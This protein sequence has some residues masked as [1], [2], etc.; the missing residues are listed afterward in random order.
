MNRRQPTPE[1]RDATTDSSDSTS[2]FCGV[3]DRYRDRNQEAFRT[4][5]AWLATT[6]R[7]IGD[8]VI[9]T[10]HDGR[11]IAMNEVAETLTGWSEAEA[12]GR[13]V[14]EVFSILR[15]K[16]RKEEENPVWQALAERRAVASA[17]DI[18]LIARDGAERRIADR[19]APVQDA[20]E[21]VVGAVLVFR[22][23]TNELEVTQSL[24]E[25]EKELVCQQRVSEAFRN[26]PPIDELCRRIVLCLI[27]GMQSPEF[28]LPEIDLG[29]RRFSRDGTVKS[30]T[31]A[32][33]ADIHLAGD[34]VGYV[35]VSYTV[36][37]PFLLPYEQDLVDTIARLLGQDLDRRHAEKARA[38]ALTRMAKTLG[39]TEAILSAL[40]VPV[41]TKDSDGRYLSCNRAFSE[42]TGRTADEIRGKTAD[43]LW[44]DQHA[45]RYHRK[46]LEMLRCGGRQEYELKIRDRHGEDREVLFVKDV[47]R[48]SEREIRGIVG[49]YIDITDRKRAELQL[50]EQQRLLKTILDGI[51]DIVAL[52]EPDHTVL[53]YNK[54][55]YDL[56]GKPPHEVHGKRCFELLGRSVPC[57]KCAMAVAI[58][59]KRPARIEKYVPELGRWILAN[60]IPIL[61][62]AGEVAM[63]VEQLQDITDHKHYEK[64]LEH[65]AHAL[66]SSNRALKEFNQLAESATRAKSEFLANMSHEIRTPMTAI[67]GFADYL[68]EE[69]GVGV[70]SSHRVDAIQTIQRNGNYLL[71]LINDILDLSKIEAGKLDIERSD[72]S[73]TKVLA[74][75]LALMRI[76]A[77]AK[78]IGLELAYV[79]EIPEVIQSDPLRFRQILINLIGN[80]IKFTESGQVH[81]VAGL[82]RTA[83]KPTLLSI[84]ITDT[85]VGLSAEQISRLFQPFSQADTSTTRKFGGSGLGLTISKRLAEKLG[86][87]IAVQSTPG[88]GSTFRVTIETGDFTGVRLL[89]DPARPTGEPQPPPPRSTSASVSLDCRVL[90]AEDGLDNQRLIALLLKRAGAEVSLAENGQVACESALAASDRGEPFDVILMDMQMPVMDGY[91]ATRHLRAEGYTG[92]I[93]A[94]TAHAMADDRQKCLDAGCDDFATKPIDRPTLLEMIARYA[95]P[96]HSHQNG[97]MA[98]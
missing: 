15:A 8:G 76:R 65:Y 81:V 55:G 3:G 56:I 71:E 20:Y 74:D 19:C 87:D 38:D 62:D 54:A 50:R 63:V 11:V 17:H 88:K 80:A 66:E 35:S 89:T 26:H 73:P 78:K 7:L 33:R 84:D 70:V 43:D 2:Q 85:G 14:T 95:A 12:M 72:C 53:A 44:P 16:T 32:L 22:D 96:S 30:E 9:N 41:F 86:G 79:G 37:R 97:G 75:V 61:D 40:P 21:A 28:A 69:E 60:G 67:L 51:P 58:A 48:G 36:D 46:D 91:A 42:F 68:L 94:L 5:E 23:L 45:Q 13:M 4:S 1:R 90:L 98:L 24:Q 92:P 77:D 39:L 82:L 10:D 29:D 93:V 59:T 25:R 52:Q 18:V 34:V 27:E 49:A 6:L 64:D 47:F 57:E 31:P 83:G